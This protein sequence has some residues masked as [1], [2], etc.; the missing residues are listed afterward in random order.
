MSGD[1]YIPSQDVRDA[2]KVFL[3]AARREKLPEPSD[4]ADAGLGDDFRQ[5]IAVIRACAAPVPEM[6][7]QPQPLEIIPT[8]AGSREVKRFTFP[9]LQTDEPPP[10]PLVELPTPEPAVEV[11]QPADPVPLPVLQKDETPAVK[12]APPSLLTVK[13]TATLKNARAGESYEDSL[14][15]DGARDLQ[16]VDDA[17]TD[18]A[19]DAEGQRVH[20][21]P[22]TAGDFELKFTGFIEARPAEIVARLAV[23]ADPKTLWTALPSD[24]SAPFAKPDEDFEALAGP[25]LRMIAASKRGRSHAKGGGFREDDFALAVHGPWQIAAVCDGAGSAALSRRGSRLASQTAVAELPALLDQQFGGDIEELVAQLET[26]PEIVGE[27]HRRL[28]ETLVTAAFKAVAALEAQAEELGEPV[29]KLSTTLILTVARRLQARW[30]IA[31]FSIG[32]GGAAVLDMDGPGVTPLTA[33]DSGEYAGQT[34]F[35]ARSEFGSFEDMAKRF[36]WAVPERFTAIALMTDGITDPKLPTDNDFA[37]AGKW[38][39]LWAD[40]LT[41][42]VDFGAADDAVKTSFLAWLD[43]WSPGNHDDRTLAVLLPRER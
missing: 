10:E 32:D 27:L 7:Q 3:N 15:I 6:E 25:D 11:E 9:P 43:F 21:A 39:A 8:R 42:G 14:G 31:A 41:Q 34:R 5:A 30:F 29:A 33:P 35:L 19:F 40:D 12:I 4:D 28:Y 24:Q 26:R 20:G 23:I 36:R 16:L 22:A 18:L 17:G 37:N 2:L 13:R 1:P 38:A